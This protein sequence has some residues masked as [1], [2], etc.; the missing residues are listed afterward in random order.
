MKRIPLE[1]RVSVGSE[2][3]VEVAEAHSGKSD[4]R[5]IDRVAPPPSRIS[6]NTNEAF[7]Q[8][9]K[10]LLARCD[11]IA[12]SQKLEQYAAHT[13][14][15]VQLTTTRGKQLW[16][17]R[18]GAQNNDDVHDSDGH[19]HCFCRWFTFWDSCI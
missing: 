6:E 4:H 17:A 2:I 19:Q 3:R 1:S 8:T 12:E 13:P 14:G 15:I 16:C 5:P 7:H 11:S 18:T 10:I 9:P